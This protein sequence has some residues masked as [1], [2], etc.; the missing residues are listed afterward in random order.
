MQKY[1]VIVVGG[2]PTGIALGIELGFN[3]INTL[4]LEKYSTPLISPRAQFINA[5]SMEF[6]IRWNLDDRLKEK[7]ICT[8]EFPNR[9]IWCSK[10]DGE[11]YA[12]S[13]SNDQLDKQLSPQSGIRVPLWMTEKILREKLNDFPC[14]HLLKQHE[15]SDVCFDKN[16]V[17]VTAKNNDEYLDFHGTYVVACDG[18]NSVIRKKIEIP[19]NSLAPAKRVMSV[20]FQ[21]PQFA[22]YIKV[23]KGS[24][25]IF[26]EHKLSG[27]VGSIDPQQGLWYAQ[28][29]YNGNEEIIS[30]IDIDSLL[31]ELTG[32]SF[33]KKI[34]NAHFWDMHIQLAKQF[35]H[36]NR[37]FLAGDS[38]HGFVPTGA[39]G[40]NTGLSDVVN[41]GWKLAS[42][43]KGEL[44]PILLKTYEKERFPI[45]LRNL[46]LSQKNADNMK[47]LQKKWMNNSLFNLREFAMANAK[48]AKQFSNLLGVTMGYAYFDSPL[49]LLEEKQSTKLM[50]KS[51]YAPTIAPGYFLPHIWLNQ[52]SIYYQLSPTAWTLIVSGKCHSISAWKKAIKK[53]PIKI[54]ILYL[55][56]NAYPKQFILIRPD[57]HIAYMSH[58]LDDTYFLFINNL[59]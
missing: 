53:Y 42:V 11:T 13:S 15:V 4:I 55:H 20:I 24:L 34:L 30:Q 46:K 29:F 59:L 51:V 41:L 10:L 23:A 56:E 3:N 9:M 28:I 32:V 26:L 22:K 7:E 5:R 49:T 31:N 38:A 40:L 27:A 25:Y 16:T 36:S 47:K 19:F 39:L 48:L 35:A 54:E 37:I 58:T 50:R 33:S 44:N 52:Q 18:T 8:D 45:C 21:A 14:V 57:W 43:I 12:I 17:I 2:G 1:D 6:C